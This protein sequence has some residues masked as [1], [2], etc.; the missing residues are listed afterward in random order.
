MDLEKRKIYLRIMREARE[1]ADFDR[2]QENK[3]RQKQN[4]PPLPEDTFEG[5]YREVLKK[6]LDEIEEKK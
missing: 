5:Q 3:K 2:K 4:L 1:R 6:L